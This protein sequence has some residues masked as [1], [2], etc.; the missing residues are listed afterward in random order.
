MESEVKVVDLAKYR[1][2]KRDK[3][4]QVNL[5]VH[6]VNILEQHLIDIA[7]VRKV[8]EVGDPKEIVDIL[9]KVFV[10]AKVRR[11][12]G[13]DLRTVMVSRSLISQLVDVVSGSSGLSSAIEADKRG[14]QM[15][16][17]FLCG[18]LRRIN[19][20]YAISGGAKDS[21]TDRRIRSFETRTRL[22]SL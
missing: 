16:R 4:L 1:E 6:S 17:L 9:S 12:H 13:M 5:P 21:D 15:E 7:R 14:D 10:D 20:G 11:R 3:L 8:Y 18:V 2:Q 22:S 19:E